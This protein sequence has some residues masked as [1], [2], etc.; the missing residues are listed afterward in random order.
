[1][2]QERRLHKDYQA[3]LQDKY[4]QKQRL[5]GPGEFFASDNK[6]DMLVAETG[7]G[8]V[9]CMYDQDVHVGG[10]AHILIPDVLAKNFREAEKVDHPLVK[11]IKEPLNDMIKSLKQKGAGKQRV[12]IRIAGGAS[13]MNDAFDIGLKNT[14][15]CQNEIVTKGL[16]LITKDVGGSHSRRIHFF[17]YTGRMEKYPMRR[18]E[19][20]IAMQKRETDFFTKLKTLYP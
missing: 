9:V 10:I 1:M 6:E 8:M 20:Q 12:R 14:V 15:F 17:P 7:A 18:E 3:F 5:V 11:H 19:D 16:P 2:V 13:I 4:W